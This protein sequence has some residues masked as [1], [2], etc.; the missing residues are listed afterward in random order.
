FLT[1]F[2]L[3]CLPVGCA[4]VT[5]S[6]KRLPCT[7]C[8]RVDDADRLLPRFG[9]IWVRSSAVNSKRSYKL[10][11]GEEKSE[12]S[13][14][15]FGSDGVAFAIVDTGSTASAIGCSGISTTVGSGETVVDSMVTGSGFLAC[16]GT[17]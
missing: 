16:T 17:C 1:D 11:T 14:S 15:S 13:I 6:P 5:G 3:D 4:A 9:V 2:F 12:S 8:L 10:N 7:G